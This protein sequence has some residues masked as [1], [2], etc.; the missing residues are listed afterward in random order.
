MA[1]PSSGRTL[2]SLG[3]KVAHVAEGLARTVKLS[4]RYLL[5]VLALAGDSTTTTSVMAS[6]G[7]GHARIV[8]GRSS[9]AENW[10]RGPPTSTWHARKG[11]FSFDEAG[12]MARQHGDPAAEFQLEQGGLDRRAGQAGAA[13]HLVDVG[14]VEAEMFQDGA[15]GSGEGFG[16]GM[17]G[18]RRLGQAGPA[19][20]GAC[21]GSRGSTSDAL[22]TRWAPVRIRSLEPRQ[23]GSSGEPGTANSSRP[24]S[25]AKRAVMSEPERG[26]ASTTMTPR[27]RPA[28]TRLRRGKWRACGAVPNGASATTQPPSAMRR[29][30]SAFSGG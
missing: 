21:A 25:A 3:G 24:I 16:G 11:R 28:I 7:A 13:D 14:R 10:Q 9:D 20:A 2:P 30:N 19:P 29:C 12:A 17:V 6:F 22:S 18:L 26:A 15:L 5:I 23:R 27:E 4:P 8:P 1:K